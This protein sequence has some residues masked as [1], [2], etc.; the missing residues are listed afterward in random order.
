MRVLLGWAMLL[1]LCVACEG[2]AR[3]G[4]PGGPADAGRPPPKADFGPTDQDLGPVDQ[5]AADR[6]M[7]LG[8]VDVGVPDEGLLPEPGP[9]CMAGTLL[10]LHDKVVVAEGPK[11]RILGVDGVEVG[12]RAWPE[13]PSG[14]AVAAAPGRPLGSA[15]IFVVVPGPGCVVEGLDERA[16]VV[17]AA[18]RDG[19]ACGA[20]SIG[21]GMLRVPAIEGAGGLL[22]AF[23]LDAGALGPALV[24][25]A[26]PTTPA[27]WSGWDENGGSHWYV[28][29]TDGLVSVADDGTVA[30]VALG[31]SPT[32]L[33]LADQD[34][35]VVVGAGSAG[36]L[37]DRWQRVA[38]RPALRVLGPPDRLPGIVATEPVVVPP[39]DGRAA[40]GGSHWWCGTG[41]FVAG[42]A[43][44][45]G[46][47][48]LVDGQR[49]FL[50]D[51]GD[52][53][54]SGIAIGRDDRIYNGGSHWQA[55]PWS[56][57]ATTL[58]D[59]VELSGGAVGDCP[60]APLLE[61]DG[62]LLAA[63]QSS[64]LVQV[65][66]ASG[67]LA[68]GWARAGGD[69]AGRRAP[70]TD[71]ATCEGG[72]VG[73]FQR[74][75]TPPEVLEPAA[76]A[77]VEDDVVVAGLQT[78]AGVGR[79]WI[80]RLD[81]DGA[82]LWT[83][84]LAAADPGVRSAL[85]VA[86]GALANNRLVVLQ[87]TTDWLRVVRLEADGTLLADLRL[88]SQ[89]PHRAVAAAFGPDGT[90]VVLGAY[91]AAAAGEAD[92]WLLPIGDDGAQGAEVPLV[93]V[94]GRFVPLKVLP[95][96]GGYVVAGGGVDG[97]VL[98]WVDGA[99][100]DR[101]RTPLGIVGSVVGLRADGAGIFHTVI[102]GDG[103]ERAEL[104]RVDANGQVL[105]RSSQVLLAVDL[106][107]RPGGGGVV[108][109]KAMQLLNF[110]TEGA[111]DPP[112]PSALEARAAAILVRE[113][114]SFSVGILGAPPGALFQQA[115]ADGRT[116]CADAGRC[117]QA[118]C[119]ED[120]CMSFTCQPSTGECIEAPRPDDTPCGG[121]LAC[122]AGVC[123]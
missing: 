99:G 51:Q 29:V 63:L 100:V 117:V 84:V 10:R 81:P 105:S 49:I 54:T 14:V 68:A 111:L 38:L 97:A 103:A 101:W 120:L 104:V 6:G 23:A 91:P 87:P 58:D 88:A 86:V 122:Q 33:A 82:T 73:L 25:P 113:G 40:N 44:W 3:D 18:R 72:V 46:A 89:I 42:G 12:A 119:A 32:A 83:K 9:I 94:R 19:V 74:T 64:E 70:Q 41:A 80:T 71:V 112:T 67:G 110:S 21:G 11:L 27:A 98:R 95:V 45:L 15:Q 118:L 36:R 76:L 79:L 61:T 65:A 106:D 56:L 53:S 4:A 35:A 8:A 77:A 50:S 123:Q 69:G 39:C 116:S 114:A 90:G 75:L 59:W 62:Q 17:W 96:A 2:P 78:A 37:A 24:L 93:D 109:G 60:T 108:L 55:G 7:S 13:A 47:W 22:L 16:R 92:H 43:G 107:V 30:R 102:N 28:G 31:L 52:F 121:R 115:S 1:G 66:T 34:Q 48:Q 57:R 85:P 20:P 26:P 5:G